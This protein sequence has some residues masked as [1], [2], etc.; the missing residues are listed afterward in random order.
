M[1]GMLTSAIAIRL[2]VSFRS[3]PIGFIG[4]PSEG[5]MTE[6]PVDTISLSICFQR[7]F[8]DSKGNRKFNLNYIRVVKLFF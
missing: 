3:S 8:N 1:K 5:V 4:Y 7:L 6:F 2:Q